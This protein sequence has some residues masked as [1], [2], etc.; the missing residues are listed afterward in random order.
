MEAIQIVT[1][2]CLA[3]EIIKRIG[4]TTC[5]KL[6]Y[7]LIYGQ[8]DVT[9]IQ[10][11]IKGLELELHGTS[12]MDEFAKWAKIRRQ[13]DSE[14]KKL[15]ELQANEGMKKLTIQVKVTSGLWVLTTIMHIFCSLYFRSDAMFFMPKILGPLNEYLHYPFAPAGSVSVVVWYYC[16][17]KSF[18]VFA[19]IVLPS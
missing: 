1:L 15:Q 13:L 2:I 5:S 17:K 10:T 19:D 6:L 12:A 3:V 8:K 4:F 9:A 16:V 7:S 14:T 11:E 18:N